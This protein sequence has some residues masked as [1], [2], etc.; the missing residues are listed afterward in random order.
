MARPYRSFSS[1]ILYIL[2]LISFLA[3]VI[4][5]YMKVQ[6][7][8]QSIFL[9]KYFFMLTFFLSG[10]LWFL[11]LLWILII[12]IARQKWGLDKAAVMDLTEGQE[13]AIFYIKDA[14]QF[15]I[16]LWAKKKYTQMDAIRMEQLIENL[17]I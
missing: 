1:N 13:L 11:V 3:M 15:I 2:C 8:R 5:M 7:Y 17:T 9:D 12:L 4:M 10:F 16:E 6:G 14:R